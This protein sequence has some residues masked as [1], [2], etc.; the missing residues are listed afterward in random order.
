MVSVNSILRISCDSSTR[1]RSASQ[2][3]RRYFRLS[4]VVAPFGVLSSFS[5]HFSTACQALRTASICRSTCLL[6]SSIFSSVIS[7]STKVTSSRMVR[8]SV[9]SAS[10][11]WMITRAIGRRARD[12]LD[13]RELA[14]LDAL[15]DLD[16]ALRA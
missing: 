11:I 6:R 5:L 1:A 8:S 13:D 10:P 4:R 15:G 2:R 12:R 9:F 16:F 7:S 14:A 3:T